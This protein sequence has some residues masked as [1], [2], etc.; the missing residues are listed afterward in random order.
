MNLDGKR[1]FIVEDNTQNRVIY[2]MILVRKGAQLEFDRW[3][4][5]TLQRIRS[6]GQFDLIILDLML[7]G[8]DS[9]YD[10]CEKIRRD[11]NFGDMPLLAV[12]AAD[13]S[14]AI[15]KAK[16]KGFSGFIAKPINDEIF[17]AQL[18]RIIAGETVWYAG[19]DFEDVG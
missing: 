1:I 7:P 4:R 19:N 10:I 5:D 8:G 17:P 16:A 2:Q 15:P 3:G 11:P 12:S 18:A 13:P 9:G 14:V 6:L